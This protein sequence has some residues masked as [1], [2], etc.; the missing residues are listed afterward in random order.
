MRYKITKALAFFSLFLFCIACQPKKGGEVPKTEPEKEVTP[1][2]TPEPTPPEPE[3]EAKVIEL[4]E[5]E[6]GEL[7]LNFAKSPSE[8]QYKG[9][10][11]A[12]VDF[13]APWC[14]YCR[15]LRPILEVLAK[16]Y[17]DRVLIYAID[18]SEEKAPYLTQ[19][20]HIEYIPALYFIPAKGKMP[21]KYN[22]G[23]TIEVLRQEIEKL[24][25]PE[26][27]DE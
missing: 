1:E 23:R 6:F 24:L 7:I 17:K 27:Q 18:V 20:L 10:L 16:E 8:W 2:P 19:T 4:S 25:K 13:Y 22:G 11:P 5:A 9:T 14:G 21:A 15:E 3:K 26:D 12:V